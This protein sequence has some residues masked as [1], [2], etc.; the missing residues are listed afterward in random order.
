MNAKQ[1]LNSTPKRLISLWGGFMAIAV[2]ALFVF[3][4]VVTWCQGTTATLNG[5]VQDATGAVIV[6]AKVE[7]KNEATGDTRHETSNGS[8]FFAFSGLPSG[9]YT[10]QVEVA[11][12]SPARKLEFT[13]T[14]AT[15]GQSGNSNCM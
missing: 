15:R 14:Q 7:L 12:F 3:V 5:T 10:V 8:G 2:V 13:L 1:I 4:P 9:D 6:N 11:G